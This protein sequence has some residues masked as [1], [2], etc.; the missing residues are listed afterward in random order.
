MEPIKLITDYVSTFVSEREVGLLEEQ[1]NH[2]VTL[3][4]TG[5]GPGSEWL[6]WLDLP[7]SFDR[8]EFQ[9]LQEA[10]FRIRKQSEVL[11]VIGIGGSYLGSRAAIELLSPSFYNHLPRER[12]GGPQ[13]FFAGTNL[14]GTYHRYLLEL[15][16]ERDFSICVVSKSGTTTEPAIAFRLFRN[17]LE[18]KYGREGARERIVAIT[19]RH[20]GA[21]KELAE[22][23]GYETFDVPEDIGGRFSVLSPVGLL[24]IAVAGVEIL[25]LMEGAEQAYHAYRAPFETNP[26]YQYAAYRK[27]L[28]DKGYCIELMANFEPALHYFAEW[29][30]Q[31]FGESEGKDGKGL[32]P[33][34]ADLTTDL[35]SLGQYIQDGRRHLFETVLHIEHPTEDLLIPPDPADLDGM[36]YLAGKSLNHVNAKALEGTLKAHASGGVPCL[37][38]QMAAPTP[39]YLGWLFYFF[40]K[41]CAISGYMLGVNPFDQPGVEAYKR[42][43][44]ELLERPGFAVRTD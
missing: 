35:H 14:S 38:L 6:G 37:L 30:K 5:A 13:I 9:R 17:L 29:W 10:A 25:E 4:E 40:Q 8:A 1:V 23:E 43:M 33:A 7:R 26:C 19:D 34:S 39:S 3:L 22:R 21:L 16:H 2:A 27:A 11:V 44:F 15:V 42:N 12:R 31:L 36:N 32:F 24:P 41:A 20:R 18:K 28:Y